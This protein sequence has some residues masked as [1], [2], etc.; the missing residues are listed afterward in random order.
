MT[1]KR[2][3]VMGVATTAASIRSF[4][5]RV[6]AEEAIG[7]PIEL[8]FVRGGVRQSRTVTPLERR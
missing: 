6:L 7:M 3:V 1:V 8:V 2:N 5:H 4:L